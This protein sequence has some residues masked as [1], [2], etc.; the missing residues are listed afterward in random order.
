[1][2]PSKSLLT[3]LLLTAA[4]S[5]EDGELGMSRAELAQPGDWQIPADVLAIGDTQYVSYT[6]AGPWIGPSGCG[7]GLLAGT[8]EL[9]DYI[10][11]YFP[12]VSGQGG[13]NCRPIN[14]NG[15][16][17][18]VHGTGRALDIFIPTI[19]AEADNDLGDPLA[20]WLIENAEFIGIQYIIWDRGQW[21]ASRSAGTKNSH[22]S[23]AH[24]HNDHLHVEL[25][26]EAGNKGTAFFMEE[27]QAPELRG[28]DPLP[29]E[30][31]EIDELSG[32]AQLLGPSQFWRYEQGRGFNDSLFW[33]NAF[34]DTE[35][36]NWARYHITLET[37]GFYRIEARVDPEFSVFARAHYQVQ[38][39]GD[40]SDVIVDQGSADGEWLEIGVFEFAEGG[41]QHLSL[42]D[43]T[44]DPVA[45]DQHITADAI[46]LTWVDPDEVP[47]QPE[48]PE[49]PED[50]TNPGEEDVGGGCNM[51]TAGSSAASSLFLL[52]LGL[53]LLARR[54]RE[55]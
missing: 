24:P 11:M 9:R 23:G 19:G 53:A 27:W 26:V 31:G 42:F 40:T 10:S 22:Y 29:P 2:T 18:S 8:G 12:Q 17:T 14:G 16:V 37:G 38:H 54:R 20:N 55:E 15:A 25:S 52:G 21:N 46:R 34:Q 33:T 32:C 48:Q 28:C 41:D 39:K 35:E 6:G 51:T 7:G 4:C 47:E 43:N 30:G 36:S 50:P 3:L 49:I 13:Y 45:D 5:V 44:P 1:M